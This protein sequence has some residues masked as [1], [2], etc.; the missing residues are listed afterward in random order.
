VIHQKHHQRYAKADVQWLVIN[1]KEQLATGRMLKE[2]AISLCPGFTARTKRTSTPAAVTQ[3]YYN[4]IRGADRARAKLGFLA[5][6]CVI[7]AVNKSTAKSEIFASMDEVQ[8]KLGVLSSGFDFY[9]A[10]KL[11]VKVVTRLVV[12]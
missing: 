4:S 9:K 11:N 6:S 8:S 7:V 1:I 10:E 2:A 3:V 5:D 12:E